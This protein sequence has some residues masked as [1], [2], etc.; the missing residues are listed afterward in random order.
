[1]S[2]QHNSEK[3]EEFIVEQNEPK[4]ILKI[5]LPDKWWYV[6]NTYS[7]FVEKNFKIL[8]LFKNQN[9]DIQKPRFPGWDIRKGD[10]ISDPGHLE[11]KLTR[12]ERKLI[13]LWALFGFLILV[14][15]FIILISSL[16]A[17]LGLG[18]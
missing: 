16:V 4:E 18:K 10:F 12:K 2:Q 5:T 1:M 7:H 15:C 17:G 3:H 11:K 13:E 9:R 14:S 6:Q 8:K